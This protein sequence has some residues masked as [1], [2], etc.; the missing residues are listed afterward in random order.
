MKIAQVAP[1]YES[2]PPKLYGGTERVVSYL[3]E[4]LVE[5]GHEVTLFASGDSETAARLIPACPSQPPGYCEAAPTAL[6]CSRKRGQLLKNPVP[7]P[8]RNILQLVTPWP[9][10]IP[11]C[12]STERRIQNHSGVIGHGHATRDAIEWLLPPLW[13]WKVLDLA[14]ARS[15]SCPER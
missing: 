15:A 8:R 11:S 7:R 2:V 3:T 14:S 1:L 5:M 4:E 6:Y 13:P 9:C 12:V 10:E